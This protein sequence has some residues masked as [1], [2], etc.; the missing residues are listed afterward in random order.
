VSEG[1]VPS[2]STNE[3]SFSWKKFVSSSTQQAVSESAVTVI[4]V[5]RTTTE[6]PTVLNPAPLPDDYDAKIEEFLHLLDSFE[7]ETET[8]DDVTA[9]Q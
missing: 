7:S 4:P 2:G 8:T 5:E 6:G 1:S 9:E 3:L